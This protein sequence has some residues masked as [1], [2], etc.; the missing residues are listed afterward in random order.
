VQLDRRGSA[1]GRPDRATIDRPESRCR[2][3]LLRAG[4]T[5]PRAL[6]A[7]PCKGTGRLRDGAF[8]I[9]FDRFDEHRFDYR[10]DDEVG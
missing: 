6:A 8:G 10:F 1:T 3:P 2:T 4:T 5:V 9:G 7:G